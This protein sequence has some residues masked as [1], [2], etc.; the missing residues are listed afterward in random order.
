MKTVSVI[1]HGQIGSALVRGVGDLETW[2]IGRV[3]TRRVVPGL[4]AHTTDA[5]GFLAHPADLIID[6]AGPEALRDLGPKALAVAPL[7]SVGA[8]AMADADVRARIA[9]VAGASG[10]ALRLFACGMAN[11]P[12]QARQLHITMRGPE[13]EAP[14]TG[15]LSQAVDRWPDRLNTAVAAALNGPGLEATMLTMESGGPGAPHEIEVEARGT[16]SRGS[17]PSAST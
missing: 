13:I 10:H 17:A 9:S 6:T 16:A 11:M 15:P 2:Q 7:W 8:V 4:A 5:Q 1:G 3:L 12:L 14:W